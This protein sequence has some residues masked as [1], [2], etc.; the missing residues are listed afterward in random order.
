MRGPRLRSR[1][2]RI[3][4]HR[5]ARVGDRTNVVSL[6]FSEYGPAFDLLGELED[7]IT[8]SVGL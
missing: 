4:N 1:R 8:Y 7:D 2:W 6:C 5:V 3:A